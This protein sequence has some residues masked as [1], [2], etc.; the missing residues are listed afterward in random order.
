MHG[1]KKLLSL[2]AVFLLAAGAVLAA[3]KIPGREENKKQE[4]V[5]AS[6]DTLYFWYTDDALTDFLTNVSAAYY[7]ESGNHVVPVLRSGLE[8]LE[9]SRRGY[10][11]D[12]GSVCDQQ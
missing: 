3:E 11:A 9:A 12:A 7:E 5:F 2:A 8:Y 6:G 4:T 10:A 1:M